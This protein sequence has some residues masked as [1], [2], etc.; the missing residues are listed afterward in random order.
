MGV[1]D[2]ENAAA[3]GVLLSAMEFSGIGRLREQVAAC[4][5]ARRVDAAGRKET[6]HGDAAVDPLIRAHTEAAA[7]RERAAA[8]SSL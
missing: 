6:P 8:G 7:L 2:P 1:F 5:E 3:A 4:A